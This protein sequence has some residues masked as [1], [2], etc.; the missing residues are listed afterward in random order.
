[1]TPGALRFDAANQGF[2]ATLSSKVAGMPQKTSCCMGVDLD[3]TPKLIL[4]NKIHP[5]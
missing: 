1:M 5:H 4:R 2:L 3:H